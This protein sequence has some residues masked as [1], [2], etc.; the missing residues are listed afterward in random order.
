MNTLLFKNDHLHLTKFGY[1]KLSLLFVSQ[2][3]S[4]LEIT[5]TPQEPQ[6][7]YSYKS[8]ISFTLN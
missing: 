3:N 4:V 5:Q 8:A 7:V 6:L 2:L 1:E